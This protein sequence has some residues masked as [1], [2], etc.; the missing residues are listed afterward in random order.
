L[1]LLFGCSFGLAQT[2]ASAAGLRFDATWWQHTN[3]DEQQGFVYGYL[4]CRQVPNAAKAS[5]VDYQNA[6]SVS[7]KTHATNDTSAVTDAIEGAAR[8]LKSRDTSGAENYSGPHGFLNGGWW[9]DQAANWGDSDRGYL[10]GYLA[11]ASPPVTVQ[12]V[13]RYQIAINHH[14]ASG[15]HDDDNIADVLRHLMAPLG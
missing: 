14:Y 4:D 15:H 3:S 6:V 10:E 7:V 11:C 13:K 2:A 1:G 12:V 9:G 5:I 8:T